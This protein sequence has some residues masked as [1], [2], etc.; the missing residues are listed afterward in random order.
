VAVRIPIRITRGERVV[1]VSALLNSGY[2]AST[3]QLLIPIWLARKLELW[4]PPVDSREEVFDTARGPL[5]VWVVGGAT[6]VRALGGDAESK[7]VVVDI[8]VSPLADEPLI[9]DRLAGA[10]EIAVEDF[11]EGLWRFRWEPLGKLRRSSPP[12]RLVAP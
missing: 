6:V 12:S 5:K 4:P 2:E 1:E 8:V 9:S 3:P 11:A 10:L 7:D